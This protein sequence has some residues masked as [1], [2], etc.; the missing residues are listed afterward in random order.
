MTGTATHD[1]TAAPDTIAFTNT[2]TEDESRALY[3]RYHIPS[4]GRILWDRA[5][6]AGTRLSSLRAA[7]SGRPASRMARVRTAQIRRTARA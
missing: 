3:R 5:P 4:S 2:F 1:T 7:R 6:D